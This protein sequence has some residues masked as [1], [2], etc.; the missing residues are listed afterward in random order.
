M[1]STSL[2]RLMSFAL[3][4]CVTASVLLGID[5]LASVESSTQVPAM[6]ASKVQRA[7]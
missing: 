1:I 6:A 7:A 2:S 4:A 3:A 5:R